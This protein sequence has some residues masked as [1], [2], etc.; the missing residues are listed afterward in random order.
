MKTDR[1]YEFGRFR[2]DARRPLLLKD[3]EPLPLKRKAVQTLLVL[4]EHRGEVVSKD[5]LMSAV[6]PDTIVEESNL[7]QYIYLLRQAMDEGGRRHIATVPGHGYRFVAEAREIEPPRLTSLEPFPGRG[8]SPTAIRRWGRAA[9]AA[10]VLTVAVLAFSVVAIR[11]RSDGGAPVPGAELRVSL[12]TSYPGHE[13]QP[14]FSA[15]GSRLAFVWDGGR[16]EKESSIYVK[17]LGGDP[18]LRLTTSPDPDHKPVWSPDG[19]YIAF[20]RGTAPQRSV[21]WVPSLGGPELILGEAD[22]GLDWSPDGRSLAIVVSGSILLLDIASGKRRS[23]TSVPSGILSDMYPVFSPDGRTV[24][25]LREWGGASELFV[26]GVDGGPERRLTFDGRRITGAAWSPDGASLLFTSNRSGPFRVWRVSASGGEPENLPFGEDAH[27]VAVARRG[28]QI[29]FAQVTQVNNIWSARLEDLAGSDPDSAWSPFLASSR[30][31]DTP[32]FSRDGRFVAFASRRSGAEEIWIGK[33]DGSNPR[34]LTYFRGP[35]TGSPRWSPDGERI[36]F[37]ASPLGSSEIYV[38]RAAGGEPRP[39]T[40]HAAS[41]I[42][43]SWS[44]DGEW[45]YFSSRRGGERQ[46]WRA[47][48]E[49]GEPVRVTGDGGFEAFESSNGEFLLYT[50]GRDTPGIWR[51]PLGGGEE[52]LIPGTEGVWRH[53]SWALAG[54]AL[55]FVRFPDGDRPRLAR[56]DVSTYEA[57]DLGTVPEPPLLFP[58]GLAVSPD[59]RVALYVRRDHSEGDIVLVENF[60]PR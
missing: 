32:H 38:V 41:D 46:I 55:Y 47:P 16:R 26:V 27:W 17:L 30:T 7:S 20:L 54:N 2:L 34:Q 44:F 23:V 31:D 28:G 14:A 49:G 21:I 45:I 13:S 50:K 42:L 11:F 29:A 53:R 15:D 59:E 40:D 10:A 37:D 18:P 33:A 19:R 24:A 52:E 39:L 60:F 9:A 43:P 8:V 56:V 25:F 57:S 35:S 5:D 12:A 22:E 36:A 4:V 58:G 1:L 51:L 6:W 3:G 48:A